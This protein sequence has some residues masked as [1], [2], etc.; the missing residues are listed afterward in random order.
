METI[1]TTHNGKKLHLTV[2]T[3][4]T[5]KARLYVEPS[6]IT[7]ESDEISD[8][9]LEELYGIIQSQIYWQEGEWFEMINE[10]AQAW[11]YEEV[12]TYELNANI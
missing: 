3:G 4:N 12:Y 2:E 8:Y 7:L 9:E 1:K 5:S 10:Q 6:M 11:G